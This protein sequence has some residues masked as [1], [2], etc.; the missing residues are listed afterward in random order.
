MT[1][2]QLI[3]FIAS[4]VVSGVFLALALNGIP[5][6]EVIASIA[7]A[8]VGWLVITF[9]FATGALFFRGVRWRRLLDDKLPL[10]PAFY[11]F[12][13]TMLLNQLPLRAGEVARVFLATR[14]R[15][16]LATAAASVVLERLIDTALVVI[17]LSFALARVP[18]IPATISSTLTLFGIAAGLGLGT[19]IF[20]AYQPR[21]LGLILDF[22]EKRIPFVWQIIARI[23]PR[24][25]ADDLTVGLRGLATA[26]GVLNLIVWTLIGWLCS[27][28]TFYCLARAL[29]IQGVDLILAAVLAVT[30]ATFS[31]AIPVSVAAVGPFEAAVVAAGSL[32][33]MGD[34]DAAALGFL[35][36]GMTVF[37]YAVWGTI[38]LLTL[39]VSLAEISRPKS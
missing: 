18:S 2:R 32:I 1:R 29:D 7:R 36:H 27:F 20:L 30:L 25:L 37:S 3:L 11:I 35:A 14:E 17:A 39:G 26:R 15:I 19:L 34:I 22:I 6:A 24:G 8:D 16:P 31:V 12:S 13:I 4:I 38:G 21:F 23:N 33:G 28:A 5:L 9:I 10:R